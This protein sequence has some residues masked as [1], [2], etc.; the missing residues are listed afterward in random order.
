[1]IDKLRLVVLKVQ[2]L[3][4]IINILVILSFSLFIYII[5]ATSGIAINDLYLIPSFTVF[6]WSL[7]CSSFLYTFPFV[8]NKSLKSE[9]F[10][11]KIKIKIYRAY[12]TLL[13]IISILATVAV[14]VTSIRVIS[15]WIRNN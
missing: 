2:W 5:F 3:K 7:L 15:I 14:I 10:L 1:M 13:A 4:P 12:Y 9:S 8:P 11:K 6:L